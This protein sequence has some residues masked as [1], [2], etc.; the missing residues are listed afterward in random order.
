VIREVSFSRRP[1]DPFPSPFF[2]LPFLLLSMRDLDFFRSRRSSRV[3]LIFSSKGYSPL[4]DRGTTPAPARGD[5]RFTPENYALSLS[6][7]FNVAVRFSLANCPVPL[8]L[9]QDAP[10]G[11]ILLK[12]VVNCAVCSH[13]CRIPY[14]PS[15]GTSTTPHLQSCLGIST[16]PCF[17]RPSQP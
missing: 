13:S 3:L 6:H 14:R 11:K 12:F 16:I 10:A 1:Y 17:S 2:F 4:S 9:A 5:V 8:P 7:L 15:S